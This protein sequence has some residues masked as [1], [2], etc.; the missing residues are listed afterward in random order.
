MLYQIGSQVI[1]LCL[2]CLPLMMNIFLK[3]Q[4]P[5]KNFDVIH[6]ENIIKKH[7]ILNLYNESHI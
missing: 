1:F 6:K 3:P 7:E 2:E 4:I 5:I